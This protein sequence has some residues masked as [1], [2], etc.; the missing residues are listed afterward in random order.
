MAVL[1][2]VLMTVLMTILSVLCHYSTV[3]KVSTVR[4]FAP[5]STNDST[6]G[7][8]CS[9]YFVTVLVIIYHDH[10]WELLNLYVT[11]SASRLPE[12]LQLAK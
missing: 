2:A 1:M 8:Y 9:T 12:N 6:F 10:V 5:H 3:R 4:L 7:L 11:D